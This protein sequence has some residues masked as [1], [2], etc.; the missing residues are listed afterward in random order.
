MD[1]LTP[2]F[3]RFSPAARVFYAGNLCQ[4]TRFDEADGAG[5]L[6][7]LRAGEL[8]VSGKCIDEQ[9]ISKP[10]VVFSPKP[11]PHTLTPVHAAGVDLVC[12]TIDLGSGLHNP[13]IEA[14]PP[15]LVVPVSD[16]PALADRIE[17]LFEEAG[18]NHCGRGAVL[19]LLTEYVL[20]LLLRHG[21]DMMNISGC[22]L[23]GLAD[24]RLARAITA[25]HERPEYPWTLEALAE[26]ATMSRARFAHNFRV[27]VGATPL[28]Y[29]TDWRLSV[30][31]TLMK[32][33]TPV[34]NVA[35][36]VGYQSPTAFSRAFS[37]RTGQTPRDWLA[38]QSD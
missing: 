3:N 1:R 9:R 13:F 4:I 15:L 35:T 30:A 8:L 21:M 22:I 6:H 18:G 37:R 28:D 16:A 10:S 29:L 34:A 24:D 31:R 14:L 17:W 38:H 11:H 32:R 12:A 27:A 7:L 33:G 26:I 36:Q 20:I 19:D 2:L 25:I 23:G 5:H